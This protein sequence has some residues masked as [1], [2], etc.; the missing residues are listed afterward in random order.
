M[1]RGVN[2]RRGGRTRL[3]S[4]HQVTIPVDALR[5]AGLNIGDML[6]AE[7]LGPGEIRLVREQDSVDR[8]AGALT[9]A[10]ADGYLDDLRREWRRRS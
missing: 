1:A 3:S 4:K 6:R 5:R 9:G 7:A 8:F 10:Y 2:E